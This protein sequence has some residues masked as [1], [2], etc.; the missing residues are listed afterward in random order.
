MQQPGPSELDLYL[1]RSEKP[2]LAEVARLVNQNENFGGL[3]VK[4]TFKILS[5]RTTDVEI[6]ALLLSMTDMKELAFNS[7]FS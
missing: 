5:G 2:Q 1:R 7:Y 3:A 6:L 4:S